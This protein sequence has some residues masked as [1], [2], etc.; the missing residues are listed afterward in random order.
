MKEKNG[1]YISVIWEEN[2]A[3]PAQFFGIRSVREFLKEQ[4]EW[5]KV[6]DN[7]SYMEF[8]VDQAIEKIDN[9]KR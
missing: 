2:I 6:L 7:K 8:I 3:Y 5:N 4:L 1:K 9:L